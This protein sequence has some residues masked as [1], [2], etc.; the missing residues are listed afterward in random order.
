M[1]LFDLF[2]PAVSRAAEAVR[3]EPPV[4]AA[5]SDVTSES[6]WKGVSG[7]TLSG[8]PSKAGV[9]VNE[10]SALSLPATLQ[11]LRILSGVF[12]MTPLHYYRRSDK[13]RISANEEAPGRLVM[14]SPNSHQTQF[15]FFELL[16]CDLLLTG[17]FYAYKS[18]NVRGEVV[19]LTRLKPGSVI[20]AE[21]FDKAEGTFLFFDATLPDGTRER[22]PAR[23]ILHIAG[24]SRD[25]IQGLNPVKFA[26]DALGE[27]L[28]PVIMHHVFGRKVAGQELFCGHHKKLL[29]RVN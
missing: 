29:K 1:G 6:Q 18:R 13:G 11:A 17:N 4:V 20:V 5:S 3:I 7:F 10:D 16:M 19:A 22:F 27:R 14:T 12:A 28:P 26:R 8:A 15:A 2:R 25:G 24:M 9:R 23:D 21:Y